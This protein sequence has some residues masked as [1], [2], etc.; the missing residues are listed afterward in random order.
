MTGSCRV[1]SGSAQG[2]RG[3]PEHTS[4]SDTVRPNALVPRL[5]PGRAAMRQG[6]LLH[7]RWVIQLS[8]VSERATSWA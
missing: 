7:L 3:E 6:L 5:V 1:M 8:E 2:F 4:S